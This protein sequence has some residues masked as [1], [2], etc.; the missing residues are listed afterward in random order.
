MKRVQVIQQ[1]REGRLAQVRAAGLLALG[2]SLG[3][4]L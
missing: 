3:S 2:K 4:H 1:V